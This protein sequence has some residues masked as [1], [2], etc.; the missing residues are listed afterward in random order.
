[1]NWKKIVL[2]GAFVGTFALGAMFSPIGQSEAKEGNNDWSSS[3]MRTAADEG[4]HGWGGMMERGHHFS[5]SMSTVIAETLN[6][7]V[8][9]LQT[10]RS[11]GKS[12]ADIAKEKNVSIDELKS[13]V[14]EARKAELQQLVKDGSI[15]QEQMDNMLAHMESMIAS[16]LENDMNGRG[17]MGNGHHMNRGNIGF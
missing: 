3:M 5:N 16:A 8:E 11:E 7:S 2:A 1:M 17:G 9:E 12:V 15:T 4:C 13:K 6:M 14:L 10:A